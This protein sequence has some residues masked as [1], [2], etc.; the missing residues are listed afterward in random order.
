VN[1]PSFTAVGVECC[2]LKL[3]LMLEALNAG[4]DTVLFVDADAYIKKLAPEL[5]TTF[6]PLKY[7]YLA[8][9]YTGRYNSGVILVRNDQHI[10]DWLNKVISRRH[11]PVSLENSVGWGEN[12]HIIQYTKDCKFVST[13]S[14]SW[15]NTFDPDLDDY[16]RHFSFGP[17]RQN[18]RLNL[19]HKILSRLTELLSKIRSCA[20][21]YDLVDSNEDILVC[22]TQKVL[23]HYQA[24]RQVP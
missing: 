18:Q 2:W 15:N 5:A 12:G 17:L 23:A 19:C 16:I 24:F 3:T 4:Y 14:R 7:L 21:R 10:R 22:L 20:G 11:E 6:R 1:Y 13:L 8:K 9:S